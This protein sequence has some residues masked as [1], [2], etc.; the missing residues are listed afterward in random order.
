[1]Y[2]ENVGSV[3]SNE[4]CGGCRYRMACGLTGWPFGDV[5]VRVRE[6]TKERWDRDGEAGQT[7]STDTDMCR[8]FDD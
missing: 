8:G 5:G 3:N 4:L 1:M 6:K 7:S 2:A